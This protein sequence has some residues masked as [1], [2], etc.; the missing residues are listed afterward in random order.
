M[1]AVLDPVLDKKEEPSAEPEEEE[2]AMWISGRIP[3]VAIKFFL[4]GL[5]TDGKG[6]GGCK[7]GGV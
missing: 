3:E 5:G 4:A 6:D 2:K 1:G 7:G